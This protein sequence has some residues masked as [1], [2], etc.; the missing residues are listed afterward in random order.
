MNP[1]RQRN[2]RVTEVPDYNASQ[3]SEIYAK[4]TNRLTEYVTR[5]SNQSG[6]EL[7]TCTINHNAGCHNPFYT[8]AGVVFTYGEESAA[9]DD[10]T[11]NRPMSVC[12]QCKLYSIEGAPPLSDSDFRVAGAKEKI[13]EWFKEY[14]NVRKGA[15]TEAHTELTDGIRYADVNNDDLALSPKDIIGIFKNTKDLGKGKMEERYVVMAYVQA[16]PDVQKAYK[17]ELGRMVKEGRS[18][19]EIATSSLVKEHEAYLKNRARAM[20][21]AF[22]CIFK[23]KVTVEHYYANAPTDEYYQ[24]PLA[25]EDFMQVNN[26]FEI[27]AY[28]KDIDKDNE[29]KLNPDR[30]GKNMIVY[31]SMSANPFATSG[32]RGKRYDN[33]GKILI[34]CTP[35][36]GYVTTRVDQSY[37][38][39]GMGISMSKF[40]QAPYKLTESEVNP[41]VLKTH[42]PSVDPKTGKDIINPKWKSGMYMNTVETFFDSNDNK[43]WR[44]GMVVSK[45][46]Y[47]KPL[48]V[49]QAM[50]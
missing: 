14:K 19:K 21:Y 23:N 8:P 36:D 35:A 50:M 9:P 45:N 27:A 43:C 48:I 32:R 26:G 42:V 17:E 28:G 30:V 46:K 40:D 5:L 22:A 13:N 1:L 47:W 12:I 3:K 7:G 39:Y 15:E 29:G 49:K 41:E 25:V 6:V 16:R 34:L 37:A 4:V 18:L 33:L 31:H 24:P 44:N 10:I 2:A 38:G 11:R 20:A